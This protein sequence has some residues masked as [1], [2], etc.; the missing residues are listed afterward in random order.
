MKRRIELA[1]LA[2]FL[3][4]AL[5]FLILSGP[6]RKATTDGPP[7]SPGSSAFLKE[8]TIRNMTGEAVSYVLRPAQGPEPAVSKSLARGAIDRIRTAVPLEVNFNNGTK[9]LLFSLEPGSAYTFRYDESNRIQIFLGS[10][11]RADAEDLAPFV[12]TPLPI[13]D[14]MLELAEVTDKDVVYD[15]GCGDGRIV[16]TA[17]RKY[18]ASG[19]GIDLDPKLIE[20]SRANARRQGVDLLIRFLCMDAVKADFSR[21]T[22]IAIYLLPES[23]ELLRPL[24]EKQLKPGSRVVCHNYTVP[25]WEGTE[26]HSV[27]LKDEQGEDHNIF[28]YKR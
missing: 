14:K 3:A 13:V 15:L 4:V 28:V 19:V 23:N 21:A 12:P 24:F 22:V 25:G 18:G 7:P 2:V 20:E 26:I 11:G 5:A 27:S 8:T 17:A 9:D 16:I 6:G 1:G 10:H